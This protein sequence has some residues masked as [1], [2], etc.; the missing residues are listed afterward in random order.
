MNDSSLSRNKFMLKGSLSHLGYDWWW[1][2]FTAINKTNNKQKAFYIEFFIINP[3]ESPDEIQYGQLNQK[4]SYT[5]INVGCWGDKP[6]QLHNFYKINDTVINQEKLEIEVKNNFLSETETFGEVKVSDAK[7]HPEYMSDNGHIK[8]NLK[9]NKIIPFN[10]GYGASKPFRKLNAFEM[11]WHAEGMK[12]KYSGTIEL[13]GE[14]YIVKP[15]TSFG[16]ADKNWGKDFTSP[17]IWISSCNLVS[18]ISGNKLENSAFNIGGGKPKFMN[19]PLD[20]KL[21][22]YIYYQGKK[23]NYN[24][25]LFWKYISTQFTCTETDKEIIW[26]IKTRNYKSKAIITCRC[27]KDEMLLINYESP[28]GK[29]RHNR[30]WNGGNGHGRIKLYKKHV[31][32]YELID[33]IDFYNAGCEYGVYPEKDSLY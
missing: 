10:V 28:D 6:L 20:K 16:Y 3:K 26:T 13:N 14:E 11:F 23:Y 24:F 15:E 1:H 17:W 2:S 30:L 27:N 7:A 18:R 32:V 4:P 25:A 22:V 19:I 12:T 9:I 5:M 29:K 8:W 33:D 31:L 21:L